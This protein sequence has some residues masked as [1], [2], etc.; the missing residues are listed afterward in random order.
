MLQEENEDFLKQLKRKHKG[1]KP[2][3]KDEEEK[4][5]DDEPSDGELAEDAGDPVESQPAFKVYML[6]KLSE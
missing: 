6:S 2:I 1:N 5:S 3:S 4:M